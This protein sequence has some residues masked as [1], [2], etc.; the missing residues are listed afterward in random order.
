MTE[1]STSLGEFTG[2]GGMATARS[3]GTPVPGGAQ[4]VATSVTAAYTTQ[5]PEGSHVAVVM[6]TAGFIRMATTTSEP[7]VANTDMYIPANT[8]VFVRLGRNALNVA[9]KYVSVVLGSGT[10]SMYVCPMEG[11]QY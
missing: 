6:T 2:L 1:R 7:A 9:H 5:L 8:L 11:N 4:V 10:G 3:M